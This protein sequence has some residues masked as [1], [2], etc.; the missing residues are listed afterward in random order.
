MTSGEKRRG[1]KRSL[2]YS[3]EICQWVALASALIMCHIA[4]ETY[5]RE[6]TRV[7]RQM[8]KTKTDKSHSG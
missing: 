1:R 5:T 4:S 8:T 2:R 3:I 7:E 6:E